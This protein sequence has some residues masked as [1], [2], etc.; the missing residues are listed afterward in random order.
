MVRVWTF[1]D[2][3]LLSA[4]AHDL[5]FGGPLRVRRDGAR[6]EATLPLAELRLEGKVTRRGVERMSERDHADVERTL[7]TKV[8]DAARFP[9]VVF[10]GELDGAEAKGTLSFAGRTLPLAV[11]VRREGG[12]LLATFEVAPSRWGVAPYSAMF[13]QLKLQDRVRVEIDAEE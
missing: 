7:T 3:G 9:D 5:R 12:R 4:V 6:V 8:I 2:A 11:P 10:R 1:K 13:G